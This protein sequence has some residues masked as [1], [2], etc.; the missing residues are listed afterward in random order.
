MDS[1]QLKTAILK[2][3]HTQ[4]NWDLTKEIPQKNLDLIITAA[5]QCPSKQNI[6]YYKI[7]AITNRT[8]IELIHD[9]TDGFTVKY[10]PYQSVTNSQ[11]LANLL[12]VIEEVEIDT[13]TGY[14]AYRNDQSL[15]LSNGSI[16]DIALSQLE[17][18]K[19]MAVGIA[20]GY[21]NLTASLLGYRTGYCACFD[22]IEVK[23]I[24]NLE[25]SPI[26]LIGIGFRDYNLDRQVHHYDHT[27]MFPTKS[28]QEIQVTYWK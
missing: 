11:V 28:K 17:R 27:Y 12:I 3:Q 10:D 24:L 26:L 19:N 15:A 21:I 16:D 20:S 7:H 1:N 25:K 5:T 8:I 23:K 9:Q 22:P 13:S 6:A 2:S 18:D 4:R 14:D